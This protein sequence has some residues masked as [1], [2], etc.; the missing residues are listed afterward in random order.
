MT[1]GPIDGLM[2]GAVDAPAAR[3]DA[4]TAYRDQIAMLQSELAETNEGVVA[5]TLELETYRDHL[6]ELVAERTAQLQVTQRELQETNSELLMLTAE[7]DARIEQRTTELRLSNERL[8][9]LADYDLVTGLRSRSW[10]T[11]ELERQIARASVTGRRLAVMFI[12][13]SE[14]LVV[15]RNLGYAAGDELLGLLASRV[16]T[17]VP[18]N[19]LIGRFDGHNLVIVCPDASDL[20][21]IEQIAND[22]LT[23]VVREAVIQGHR[24]SRTASIGI[25]VSSRYSTPLSL[26]READHAL[27]RAKASGRNRYY[28]LRQELGDAGSL[29][30]FELEHELREALD[31][32]QFVLHYQPQVLL[33]TAEIT[34]YEALVRWEHPIRGL[35]SPAYFMD[36][37]EQSG[38]V[39]AL[40]HQVIEQACRTLAAHPD[41]P[42]PV[43]V[44]ASAVELSEPDWFE[45]LQDAMARH[46]VDPTR[47]I[48]ELT[49]TTMLQLTDDAKRS[50]AAV[51][52]TGLGIHIDDFGTGYASVG[53]LRQVPVTALKLDRSFVIPLE[54]DRQHGLDLV[55]G[56]AGLAHGLGLEAIAE[57]VETEKQW[58]LLMAAGWDLGQ[59]YLFGRPAAEPVL[60]LEVSG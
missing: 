41:L 13:L 17:V 11:A 4:L 45:L 42:G 21:T 9:R 14:F 20:E 40:C 58:R 36:T 16:S 26:L 24:I 59:G 5:L 7:L 33:E 23:Q 53:L 25:A 47:L 3:D 43:S 15:N 57:G 19:C 18:G 55:R 27:G 56:I 50:L 31:A 1:D 51:R 39:V 46:G 22:V 28:V 10:I 52:D 48:I 32:H 37:M 35:L 54:D 60:S 6:E 30:H 2:A 8:E 29:L 12:E 38:L 34:G 44:N 49:E